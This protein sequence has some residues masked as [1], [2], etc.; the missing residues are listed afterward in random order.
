MCLEKL[1]HT[2]DASMY[3][4]LYVR[5]FQFVHVSIS[6]IFL[7]HLCVFISVQPV[8]MYARL[9]VQLFLCVPVSGRTRWYVPAMCTRLYVTTYLCLHPFLV[10]T[11]LC[12]PVSMCTHVY[13]YSTLTRVPVSVHALH[14][15][16]SKY[17]SLNS[18]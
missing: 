18:V 1:I 5:P 4:L 13:V 8:L 9:Y 12:V 6:S 10:Y 17:L 2:P 14:S 7:T 11:Y 16:G 15:A 3:T